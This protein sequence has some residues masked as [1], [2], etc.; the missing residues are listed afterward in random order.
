MVTPAKKGTE[1]AT[2]VLWSH[3]Y[4]A[5]RDRNGNLTLTYWQ[6]LAVRLGFIIVFEVAAAEPCR[7]AQGTVLGHGVRTCHLGEPARPCSL[8][9]C[10]FLYQMCDC[11]A[12]T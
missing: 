8:L 9:A 2:T 4:R 5:F 10:S 6:L 3:R 7:V 1:A 11:M 12:G